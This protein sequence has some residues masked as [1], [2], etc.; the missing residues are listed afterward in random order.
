M[1]KK[2]KKLYEKCV[3]TVFML[4]IKFGGFYFGI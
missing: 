4:K 3:I 1:L 2:V